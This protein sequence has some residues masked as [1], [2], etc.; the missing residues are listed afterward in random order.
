MVKIKDFTLATKNL[1]GMSVLKK[2]RQQN[3]ASNISPAIYRQ[4]YI[5]SNISPV[6]NIVTK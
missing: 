6:D 3:I 5:A 1:G 2:Y 4:Q